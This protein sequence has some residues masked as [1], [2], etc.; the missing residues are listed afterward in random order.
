MAWALDKDYD[1]ATIA[2]G[3]LN[4]ALPEEAT[5][6]VLTVTLTCG[7][8]TDTASYEIAVSANRIDWRSATFAVE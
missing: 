8:I 6:I 4:I 5:T 2:D 7:E 3:V 1:F